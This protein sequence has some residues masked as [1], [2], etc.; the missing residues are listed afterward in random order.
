M[1]VLNIC[2]RSFAVICYCLSVNLIDYNDTWQYDPVDLILFCDDVV[3][4]VVALCFNVPLRRRPV[5]RQQDF[6]VRSS[7]GGRRCCRRRGL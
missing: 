1:I 2:F 7:V 5:S 6:D 3:R 4:L